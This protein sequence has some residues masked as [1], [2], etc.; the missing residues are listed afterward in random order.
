MQ[1]AFKG[2]DIGIIY[3]I[4][5]KPKSYQGIICAV[6]VFRLWGRF[7]EM[8]FGTPHYAVPCQRLYRR[9]KLWTRYQVT[10]AFKF[11]PRI[12]RTPCCRHV[13]LRYIRTALRSRIC[14]I[15]ARAKAVF[16]IQ[17]S[18]KDSRG[19]SFLWLFPCFHALSFFITCK[20]LFYLGKPQGAY[21][22][23]AVKASENCTISPLG[24][25]A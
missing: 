24:K 8:S 1:K 4:H 3:I 15:S 19:L 16:N 13:T 17:F 23:G 2:K 11:M 21:S 12:G 6:S 9:G 7:K 20:T 18:I 14:I 5:M 22:N 25:K 10:V